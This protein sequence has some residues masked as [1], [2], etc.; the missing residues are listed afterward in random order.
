MLLHLIQSY[1]HLR[2]QE[3]SVWGAAYPNPPR[4][5]SRAGHPSQVGHPP[6]L[7]HKAYLQIDRLQYISKSELRTLNISLK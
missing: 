7:L 5:L 1:G 3:Q 6:L 4:H 2:E